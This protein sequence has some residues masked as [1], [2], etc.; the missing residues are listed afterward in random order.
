M[1]EK[2]IHN[3]A[4]LICK[5]K[6]KTK[7]NVLDTSSVKMQETWNNRTLSFITGKDSLNK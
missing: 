2:N 5:L 7:T 3:K 6:N 4:I 1:T